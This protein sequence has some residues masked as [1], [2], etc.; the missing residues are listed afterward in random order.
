MSGQDKNSD[1]VVY[2]I[3]FCELSFMIVFFMLL[4]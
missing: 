2:F 1:R 4:Y 3:L